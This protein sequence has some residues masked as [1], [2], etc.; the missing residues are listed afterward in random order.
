MTAL[1]GKL[2]HWL[3][4]EPLTSAGAIGR[5]GEELAAR[6]LRR[7]GMRIVVRNW[8]QGRSELDIVARE[9]SA[10]VFVEVRTRAQGALVPGYFT[11][12]Q[13]KRQA[14]RRAIQSYLSG[15]A[16]RPHTWR[17]DVVEVAVT[18]PEARE[19]EL[20]RYENVSL[21]S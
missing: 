19:A 10:L 16:K 1:V 8:R 21:G 13:K 2:R 12:T 4:P 15:L 17:L 7:A 6:E 11:L 3:R 14:L 5:F 9:G 18:E 20:R